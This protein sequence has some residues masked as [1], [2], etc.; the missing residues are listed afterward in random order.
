MGAT[1]IASGKIGVDLLTHGPCR[2]DLAEEAV[3]VD[4]RSQQ[5]H[6]CRYY[7]R[8]DGKA[9]RVDPAAQEIATCPD[10]IVVPAISCVM[11][12]NGGDGDVAFGS[13][14]RND[15]RKHLVEPELHLARRRPD[16]VRQEM[17]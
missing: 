5:I 12:E 2:Q 6:E 9:C 7:I 14:K 10:R 15:V 8:S 17:R 4:A 13:V 16:P 11:K 3:E 1:A